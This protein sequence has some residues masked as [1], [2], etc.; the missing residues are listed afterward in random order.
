MTDPDLRRPRKRSAASSPPTVGTPFAPSAGE[1]SAPA[2]PPA[3][4]PTSGRLVVGPFNRVEGDLEV[5]LEVS[6]GHVRTA[7]VVSPMYR[8]FEN[9][10]VGRDPMDALVVVPR[11]CGICSVSQSVAA[12]R[13]LADAAGVTPPPNGQ[14]AQHLMLAIENAADHLTHF[15]LFFL[16]DFTRPVYAD[17]GWFREAERRHAAQGGERGRLALAARQRGFE[18]M[19]TLGGRWPHTHSLHPGGTSRAIE[20]A[21][22][23]RL[24]G[25]V[26]EWRAFLE[27]TL[28][29]APIE[30]V[31]TLTDEAALH[32]WAQRVGTHADLPFFLEISA[33]LGLQALGPGPGRLL[34]HGAFQMSDPAHEHRAVGPPGLLAEVPGGLWS[35][36]QV[37]GLDTGAITEDTHHTW[38]NPSDTAP[39][40]PWQGL[41]VPDADKPGAYTWNKAPRLDG[42]TA[43]C[44]ALARQ[45]LRRHP[46]MLDLLARH[47]S[48]VH[49]R[50]IARVL[51]LAQLVASMEDWLRRM[52][53][54]EPWSVPVHLPDQATGQGLTEA[55]RG[56]LGHWLRIERGRLSHYQIIAPTSWNFSPRDQAGIPGP[57]EAALEG[58]PVRPGER[59]PVAVQHIVRSFD[60]CMVCTVH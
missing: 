2:A 13:A 27:Q 58:A 44:G 50:V 3:T 6:D 48:T 47:G 36:D 9:M 24:I 21:E 22:R 45:A 20:S 18:L 34:C 49:T 31:L 55:A 46:L 15:Y 12:A 53:P 29:G 10:L 23:L 26:R 35:A 56:A 60:P 30:E 11:I 32:G 42:Q 38:L 19:G 43:E 51:E 1:R 17:R 54:R 7:Q 14:R 39:R 33:D 41:T 40:P 28:L 59:T 5:R 37:R 57:L 4:A 25:R 16:P 8:G 52:V